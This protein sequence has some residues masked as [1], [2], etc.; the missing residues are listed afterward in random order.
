MKWNITWH[1]TAG[2][3]GINSV[4]QDAYHFIVMA[5][6][7][8]LNGVDRPEDNIPPL[9]P[10]AYAAS[11]L[12]FNSYNISISVDAMGG[13]VERPFNPGKWPITEKQIDALVALTAKLCAKYDVPVERTRVL[14]HAEVQPTLK[15]KQ[16]NK[17]DITWLPGMIGPKDPVMVG[18][19]LRA[20]VKAYMTKTVI[21]EREDK[22]VV[23]KITTP[24]S[25]TPTV[26]KTKIS[27]FL[28]W[29]KQLFKF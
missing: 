20:R 5:D 9:K 10:G 13:A 24:L 18:D 12:G 2:A 6:G 3:Y 7:T 28:D 17:W 26:A 21:I 22:K 25:P 29:L 16:R 19:I 15:I 27:I 11:T 23:E 1:W 14:S 4:E 8:V